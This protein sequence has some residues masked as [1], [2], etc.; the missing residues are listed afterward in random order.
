MG[1]LDVRVGVTDGADHLP[2]QLRALQHVGFVYRAHSPAAPPSHLKGDVG[3][4]LDLR[5]TIDQR[6]E[7]S[8][9]TAVEHIDAARFA[10]INTAGEFTHD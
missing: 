4:A 9:L 7:A 1:E 10:K 3:D 6:V 5:L 2:P 8:S